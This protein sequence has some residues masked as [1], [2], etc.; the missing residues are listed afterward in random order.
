MSD[1]LATFRRK[2]AAQFKQ[3]KGRLEFIGREYVRLMAWHLVKGTPG[4]AGPGY[5]GQYAKTKYVPTGRLRGGWT[6]TR[7]PIR[8]TS[9]GYNAAR[10]EAGPFS[11]YGIETMARIEQQLR[12]TT[13]AGISYLENDV[14]YADQIVRGEENH[15][16]IGP[17]NWPK[18]TERSSDSL[19]QL[20]MNTPG[21]A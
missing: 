16:H 20:A 12:A 11:D 14:A 7:T 5:A 18:S 10:N 3:A 21:V 15:A 1:D 9:K 4:F 2:N 8:A 6:W 17:R 19:A 13:V